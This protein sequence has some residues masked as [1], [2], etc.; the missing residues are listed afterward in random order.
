[1]KTLLI[2]WLAY[3]S[4]QTVT[5]TQFELQGDK[6]RC[7]D[8]AKYVKEILEVDLRPHNMSHQCLEGM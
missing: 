3:N 8:V 5:V 4:S 2:I 6:A 1:M 7:E